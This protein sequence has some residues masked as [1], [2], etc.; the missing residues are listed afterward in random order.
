MLFNR[1]GSYHTHTQRVARS[2]TAYKL[3]ACLS[4]SQASN[5]YS[6]DVDEISVMARTLSLQ[7]KINLKS[8]KS[9]T[10]S[11]PPTLPREGLVD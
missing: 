8:V 7:G 1:L 11:S 3:L 10:F 4:R 6:H 9:H 5:Y 2:Y